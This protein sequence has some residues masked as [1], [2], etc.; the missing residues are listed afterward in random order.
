LSAD[1]AASIDF[2]RRLSA[3]GGRVVVVVER[4]AWGILRLSRCSLACGRLGYAQNGACV[5][6]A[7]ALSADMAETQHRDILVSPSPRAAGRALTL[8]GMVLEAAKAHAGPA[9]RFERDGAWVDMSYEALG[10]AAREI[11][12]GLIALGIEPGDRIA[13]LATTRAEWTLVDCGALC[14]G[15]V[16]VPIYHTNSPDECRYVLEHSEAR[17]VFCEDEEQL[18]KIDQIRDACPSLEHVVTFGGGGDAALSL[19]ALRVHAASVAG[20]VLEEVQR[21]GAPEQAATIIYTSGTTG[22]P[23]GC[24][25]THANCLAAIEMYGDALDLHDEPFVVFLFL[26]LAHALTRVAQ[27]VVL[28]RGGTLA[29]WRHDMSMIP[30]DLAV[31]RPTHFPSVPRVFEKIR[32]RALADVEGGSALRRRLFAWALR[33]GRDAR[34][35]ERH[36]ER[37]GLLLRAREGVADRLVLSKI[38]GLFGGEL[39]L[40]LTGAAPV[41]IDV[42][43]FF[44]ACGVLV[45]EGYGLTETCAATTLNT[46]AAFRFGS[47]GRSLAD[48]ELRIASDG[49]V[50]IRGPNV[51]RGYHRD[52]QATREVLDGN[53]L[54]SGD[55]GALDEVG[56]LTIT[57][58]KKDII[59]TSSGKNVT[60]TNIENA[61][62]ESRWVSQAVVYGDNRPYLVALLTLDGDDAP[63]LAAR[64][65]VDPDIATMARDERVRQALQADVDEV[66][67]RFARIEQIKR[68]AI[69]DHELTQAAGEL[70]PT[71]K[72][73]RPVVYNRYAGA[74][75]RLY[76]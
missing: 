17:L 9:L 34:E 39:R 58:R 10:A 16:V 11:A 71:M 51:F 15:A 76:G 21:R 28:D 30:E 72:I 61:L 45:L 42:L 70:T 60:P 73:K 26:P 41:G 63:A 36:G 43:E 44:D 47:V 69:L 5:A 62:R 14:A 48:V 12:L 1:C 13:V 24:V 20:D 49:E 50:L 3:R 66:N 65:G 53:W 38:R 35:R 67:R 55:L 19:D 4:L 56:Y 74:F 32:G 75:D 64:L 27:M 40:A 59:I 57:G 31:T 6:G 7:P 33:I 37:A 29:Y 68:F 8:G 54:R 25:L 52:E 2:S 18:V 23:K 22:P 46:P